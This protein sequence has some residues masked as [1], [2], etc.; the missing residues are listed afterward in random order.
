M[1]NQTNPVQ[2]RM[3]YLTDL[4]NEIPKKD[5]MIIRTI[6]EKGD[7]GMIEAF[8]TYMLGIGVPIADI[9]VNFS[10]GFDDINSFSE[11]LVKELEGIVNIWNEADFSQTSLDKVII[12]WKPEYRNDDKNDAKLF[13]DN[14]NKLVQ[15]LNLQ[16]GR[17]LIANLTLPYI[18]NKKELNK[19]LKEYLQTDILSQLKLLITDVKGDDIYKDLS[20]SFEDDIYNWN[21]EIDTPNVISKVAAMGDPQDPSTEYRLHFVNMMN[22]IGKNKSGLAKKEGKICLEIAC[23]NVAKDPYWIA[24]IVAVNIVLSNEMFKNSEYSQAFETADNAIK[25][26][27]TCPQVLG[28]TIGSGIFAQAQMNKATMLSMKKKW[29]ESGSLFELAAENLVKANIFISALEAYRMAAYCAKKD[30]EDEYALNNLI[31]GYEISSHIDN[32]TLR[33]STFSLLLV[34]ILKMNY[35][36]RIS[37]DDL[38]NRAT[39]VYGEYWEEVIRQKWSHV[40]I[41]SLYENEP[42]VT[43]PGNTGK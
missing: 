33:N 4:W 11:N 38:N 32:H 10:C 30:S 3:E 41:D 23:N 15:V 27:E 36:E 5:Y 2:Q 29:R 9:A 8:Y 35:D 6:I 37:Y 18:L 25:M 28:E 17:F 31:K 16:K 20:F 26:G 39:Q 7:E 34:H 40:N 19:W 1:V 21:P 42:F 14:L 12:G 13:T 43:T 24:Q 22:A